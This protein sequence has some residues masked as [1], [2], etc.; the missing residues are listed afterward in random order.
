MFPLRPSPEAP[1]ATPRA[2]HLPPSQ[3]GLGSAPQYPW[4]REVQHRPATPLVS[5]MVPDLNLVLS[6]PRLPSISAH[7]I[8]CWA[9]QWEK[10]LKR[11]SPV[12]VR[13]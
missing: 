8:F 13:W 3:S 12:W 9:F 2:G 1:A 7:R 5:E 11:C 4:W 6:P 10:F